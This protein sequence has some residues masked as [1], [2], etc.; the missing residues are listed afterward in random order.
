MARG[1]IA[2]RF[3]TWCE[4]RGIELRYIQPGKPEQNAFIERFNRTYRTEVLNAYV[5]E[6]LYQVR[7]ISAE[8]LQSYNEERP[9]DALAGLPPTMYR[10]QLEARSSPVIV[11]H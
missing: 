11:S 2:D 7:E 5:F 4:D 6:S 10:A 1:L 8:W 9:H 3:M